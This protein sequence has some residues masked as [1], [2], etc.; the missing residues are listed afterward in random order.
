MGCLK[1]QVYQLLTS[2]LLKNEVNTLV[3]YRILKVH[4]SG[5]FPK[6]ILIINDITYMAKFNKVKLQYTFF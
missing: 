5:Y 1:C 3:R 6:S 4:A 2:F